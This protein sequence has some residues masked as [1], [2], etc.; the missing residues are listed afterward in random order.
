MVLLLFMTAMN[1]RRRGLKAVI[2]ECIPVLVG[3]KPALDA[4]RV[5][6]GSKMQEG[7]IVDPLLEMTMTKNVEMFAEAIPGVIIQLSA[8][9]SAG[10]ASNAATISLAISALTTGFISATMSYDWDT[11]P[12][13]RLKSSEFYGYIPDSARQRTALFT[14]MVF[15]SALMLLVRALVLVMLGLVSRY[16]A[17][18]YFGIDMGMY[19]LFKIVRDDFFY[20]LPFEG[21][22]E[23]A[24]SI[25]GRVM[26]KIVVDFTGNGKQPPLGKELCAA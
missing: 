2:I 15:I 7:K 20:W 14:S 9:L 26:V 6:S 19:L 1:N 23:L 4:H 24:V 18:C 10:R 11:D 5:V 22:M 17:L 12:K 16:A 13:K 3:L 21:G 8:I 25:I